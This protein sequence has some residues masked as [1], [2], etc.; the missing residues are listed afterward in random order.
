[1]II[2]RNILY[3]YISYISAFTL[4]ISIIIREVQSET[5]AKSVLDPTFEAYQGSSTGCLVDRC[6]SCP[7]KTN[8]T[9]TACKSGY[10]LRSYSGSGDGSSAYNAC[11]SVSK[12]LLFLFSMLALSLLGCT[13]CYLC[14][15]CGQRAS[16]IRGNPYQMTHQRTFPISPRQSQK[17]PQVQTLSQP[18]YVSPP[19]QIVS[20]PPQ[21]IAQPQQIVQP[22]RQIVSP[23]RVLQPVYTP[24]QVVRGVTPVVS[25]PSNVVRVASPRIAPSLVQRI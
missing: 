18:K 20:P 15:R 9:C 21:I 5:V 1:M 7:D 22:V 8:L 14:Y 4:T 19:R 17:V 25:S 3:Q 16:N 11:W 12:L 24:T 10:Y 23:P 2:N 13:L 6:A